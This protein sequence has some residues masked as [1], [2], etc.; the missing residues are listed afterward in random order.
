MKVFINDKATECTPGATLESILE[1]NRVDT[2]FVAVALDLEVIP[3]EAWRETLPRDGS[4]ILV[5][6]AAQGG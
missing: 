5:I 2:S 1:A 3:R 6:T 4:Q